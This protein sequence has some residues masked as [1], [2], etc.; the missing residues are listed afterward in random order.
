MA[1]LVSLNGDGVQTPTRRQAIPAQGKRCRR[2]NQVMTLIARIA[3]CC[4]VAVTGHAYTAD[5]RGGF[6]S[7]QISG[8]AID[9]VRYELDAGDASQLAAV[10]FRIEPRDVATVTVRLG[11]NGSPDYRC[12]AHGDRIRCA[13]PA[14]AVRSIQGLTVIAAS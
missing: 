12:A 3:A 13:T 14:V 2:T 7:A 6:G 4:L 5:P 9:D 11:E 8:Y 1:R 10:S